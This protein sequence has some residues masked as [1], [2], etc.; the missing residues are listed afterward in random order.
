MKRTFYFT[1]GDGQP[2]HP[3]YVEVNA[4]DS[5]TAS[6]WMTEKYGRQ[7]CAMYSHLED[8]H[9]LDRI[10]RDVINHPPSARKKTMY[11]SFCP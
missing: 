4:V 9:R 6:H 10:R 7:W 3:G 8:I 11:R 5:L 1:F 2:Y